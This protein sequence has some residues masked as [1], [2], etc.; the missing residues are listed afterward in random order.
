MDL[1]STTIKI[2]EPETETFPQAQ[3]IKSLSFTNG[4]LKPHHHSTIS[5][6]VVSYKE[7][8][9]N[10][11]ARLG[12][13]ALDGCGEFMPSPSAT[14][15]DPTS[16]KCAAC[17]CHRNFHRRD[18]EQGTQ[19]QPPYPLGRSPNSPSPPP[20]PPLSSLHYSS[21]PHMLLSLSAGLSDNRATTMN[22]TTTTTTMKT[23]EAIMAAS[24]NG[25]KRLRTKFSKEQK[26][27]MYMFAERVG[28]KMQKRDEGLVEEFCN[29]VGVGKGVFKVWMHNNKYTFGKG[30]F[31]GGGSRFES[32][33]HDIDDNH[34]QQ[35]D[36]SAHVATN[37][38]SSSS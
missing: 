30:D 15:T 23:T 16:L 32:N 37:G 35:D 31:N 18:P 7:C 10:H 8:L 9:K 12:G 3:P 4:A 21:A 27:K 28:W 26:D 34:T 22:T 6:V 14:P 1:T 19:P 33:N 5:A 36:S 24:P 20:P 2:P 13:H 38:S 17:G 29:E 11:A 25:R